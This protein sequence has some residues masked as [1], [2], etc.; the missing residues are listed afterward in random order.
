M[1]LIYY[2]YAYLRADGTPYYIGKGKDKRAYAKHSK[3]SATP[4]DLSRVIFVEKN[5][6]ELGAVAIERRLIRWYGRKD[7]GTGILRNM[8]EGG[9]GN[10]NPSAITRARLSAAGM[11]KTI[12]AAARLK[13]SKTQTG[14]P[15]T[16][17]HVSNIREA[18]KKRMENPNT[19]IV[20]D[21][22]SWK[23][24]QKTTPDIPFNSYIDLCKYLHDE[25]TVKGR[26]KFHVSNELN[27]QWKSMIRL[28][29]EAPRLLSL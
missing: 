4:T 15:K 9:E 16:Q 29:R 21:K 13:S 26:L 23:C 7:L 22:W 14:R 24:I 3:N 6:T 25:I 10:S 20:A 28:L 11:G 1:S 19:A 2:V 17:E 18:V 27:L 5:L 8:T 12:S